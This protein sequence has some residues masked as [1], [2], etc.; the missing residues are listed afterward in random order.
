MADEPENLNTH[1]LRQFRE[2]LFKRMDA[3]DQKLEK[4]DHK[5]GDVALTLVAVQ[6]D[7]RRL[8]ASVGTLGAAVD[9]IEARLA[10]LEK[11]DP[12][13]NA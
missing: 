12:R 5:V 2:E 1:H 8:T 13:P 10:L 3:V 9:E 7:M 11:R 4:L 6:R